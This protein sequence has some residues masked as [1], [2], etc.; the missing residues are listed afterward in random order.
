[1]LDETQRRDI[2]GNVLRAYGFGFARYSL[3]RVRDP[4]GARRLLEQLL[5]NDLITSARTWDAKSKPA[6][7]LNVALT[8]AGLAA[9][10][11]PEEAL[12]S[13]PVEFRQGMPGRAAKLGDIGPNDPSHWEFGADLSVVHVLITVHA[14]SEADKLAMLD[15]L[16]A[17]IDLTGSPVEIVHRLDAAALPEGTEHFGHADGFG[18]PQIEGSGAPVFPGEGTP[19]SD[20]TWVPLKA[21][22]F[23]LGYDSESGLPLAMPEPATLGKNG[24]FLVYRQLEQNVPAYRQ[25]LATE[26][27]RIYGSTAEAGRLS[28]KVIGRWR[29]GCPLARAPL[30][31]DPALAA[32]WMQNNDF[33]YTPDPTGN[34]CPIDAHVR[35]M[36]PRDAA[37]TGVA[38]LHRIIRR[39]LPYG[40]WLDE[41][42][43]DDGQPRGI[44][45]MAISASIAQGFEFLQDVWANSG[46]FAGRD[47]K[48]VDPLV[49][50]RKA[51][52]RFDMRNLQNEPKRL[53]LPQFVTLRGGGYFFIPSLTALRFISTQ[54]GNPPP[55]IA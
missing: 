54:G 6:A 27:L 32:D 47:A 43:V 34:I 30:Q 52:A 15:V 1:M 40:S 29:S 2:Q 23:I 50:V 24:S 53:S 16:N 25:F 26:A 41:G 8:H 9:L 20:G 48:E 44:A 38:R 19:V 18:Q 42:V 5:N 45:F 21:G 33:R 39:G 7:A 51:G 13:F 46:E 36:N 49:G 28:G 11:L 55:P 10:G 37:I 4:L 12:D 14:H 3:M 22:E 35:R 17:Q 31:D